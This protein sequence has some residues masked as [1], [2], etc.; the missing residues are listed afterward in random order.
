[1]QMR[2]AKVA[3]CQARTPYSFN[4]N[5]NPLSPLLTR[6]L[7]ADGLLVAEVDH[8]GAAVIAAAVGL[9]EGDLEAV[10]TGPHAV[11][12]VPLQQHKETG[13]CCLKKLYI[14]LFRRPKKT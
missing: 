13:N 12:V 6:V 7:A 11:V 8:V 9:V 14:S 3:S 10:H 5:N 1:M 4:H 2:Q